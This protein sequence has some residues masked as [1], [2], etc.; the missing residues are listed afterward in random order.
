MMGQIGA[1]AL[2]GF[3]EAR[4]NR[5]TVVA[6]A[7]AVVMILSTALV[8]D[9]TIW[10]LDRVLTDTGLGA[11]SLLSVFL[12]VFLSA[13]LITKEIERRTIFLVVSRPVS[14]AQFIIGR[15]LGNA[16]T[17]GALVAAMTVI[18][19]VQMVLLKV[20]LTSTMW[21]AITG[22]FFEL[23][24]LTSLG[25]LLSSFASQIVSALTVAA[26]YVIG[27]LSGD[28]YRF[29]NRSPVEVVRW[30]GKGLYYLLPNLDR[31]DFR[32][33][34]AHE[35]LVPFDELAASAAYA[36]AYS[37]ALLVLTIAIFNRRDFK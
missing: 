25:F 5:V 7:F 16:L 10:T 2:N 20:P 15:W 22:L 17:L 6:A 31:L 30:L 32:M 34:A 19:A 21:V 12:A 9:V 1:I 3:R 11:M 8:M 26:L 18:F 36:C 37:V 29:A 14:R 28:L 33:K 4:R 13:G 23:L 24:L 35:Q 27:H